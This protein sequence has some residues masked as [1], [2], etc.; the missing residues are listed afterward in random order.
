MD[1]YRMGAEVDRATFQLQPQSGQGDAAEWF[2][3]ADVRL[4]VQPQSGQGGVAE[5]FS[6][7]DL[8]FLVQPQSGQGGAAEWFADLPSGSLKMLTFSWQ[9]H[10]SLDKSGLPTS[11]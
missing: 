5:W 10:Q 1:R 8:R 6:D 9:F 7:V 2:A 3:D 4:R 11:P